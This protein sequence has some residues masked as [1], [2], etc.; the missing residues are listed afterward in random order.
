MDLCS[1][2]RKVRV[3]VTTLVVMNNHELVNSFIDVNCHQRFGKHSE[4]FSVQQST[5]IHYLYPNTNES[6][7]IID[8]VLRLITRHTHTQ[9]LRSYQFVS[10]LIESTITKNHRANAR[11]AATRTSILTGDKAS[12]ISCLCCDW[13]ECIHSHAVGHKTMWSFH[14]RSSY[15]YSKFVL[16]LRQK[17]KW[18]TEKSISMPLR[19]NKYHSNDWYEIRR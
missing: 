10:I 7:E 2:D 19:A 9:T 18:N 14:I 8:V 1:D 11:F 4:I 5:C 17:P 16:M 3:H 15:R 13:I 12:L 6:F